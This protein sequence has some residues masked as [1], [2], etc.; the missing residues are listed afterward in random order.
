MALHPVVQER[1]QEEISLVVGDRLAT[2]HDMLSLPY[3]NAVIKETTRWGC[4][5][6][7]GKCNQKIPWNHNLMRPIPGIPH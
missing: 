4:V 7:L 5:A 3:V 6:P 2:P 1:A